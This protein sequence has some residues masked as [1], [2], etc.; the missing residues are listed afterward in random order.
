MKKVIRIT[1]KNVQK[2]L[3][4]DPT[5]GKYGLYNVVIGEHTFDVAV[6]TKTRDMIEVVPRTAVRREKV[7]AARWSVMAQGI[8]RAAGKFMPTITS[9]ELHHT[10]I[11]SEMTD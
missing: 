4:L 2:C 6:I 3:H 1:G 5:H 11:P 8:A 10:Y 7:T 9:V